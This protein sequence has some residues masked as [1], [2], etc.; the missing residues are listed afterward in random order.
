LFDFLTY[1][2]DKIQIFFLVLIRA[3]GLFIIAPIFSNR[4]IPTQVKVSIVIVLT[5]VMMTA[6]NNVSLAPVS[7]LVE[8]AGLAFKELLVG[9]IIGLV[10]MLIFM[11]VQGAGSIVGYQMG[12]YLASALDPMTQGQTSIIGTFWT[13]LATLVFVTINGHHLVITALVDSYRAMPPGQVLMNGSVGELIIKY[14]AYVFV[15]ALKIASPVIVTLFLVDVAMGTVAKMMPTMNVFFV[16][17]PVKIFA[18]L[19]VMALSM[20]I[21]QYV[22]EKV[23]GYLNEELGV[24]LLTMGK[25]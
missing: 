16:G 10:F 25:V 24:L 11:G 8:L 15:I 17:F 19:M 3:S 4:A 18:G 1:S 23:T 2:L 9:A 21:F 12:M 22:L 7:S 13:L 14:T 5:V 20:P 6:L